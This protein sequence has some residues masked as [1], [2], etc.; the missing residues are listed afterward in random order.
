MRIYQLDYFQIKK[1]QKKKKKNWKC[2]LKTHG[3]IIPGLLQ[4]LQT[5]ERST[6]SRKINVKIK[7]NRNPNN[8]KTKYNLLVY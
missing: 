2:V 7:F 5:K 4:L 3:K 8:T 6:D 1:Q